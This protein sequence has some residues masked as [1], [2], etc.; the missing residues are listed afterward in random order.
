[1]LSHG[2]RVRLRMVQPR[3]GFAIRAFLADQGLGIDELEL[4]RLLRFDPRLRAVICASA[5]IDAREVIVAVGGID[6]DA[7]T[8]DTLVVDDDPE[9]TLRPLLVDALR[10][11]AHAHAA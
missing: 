1:M 3:D 4:D 5:L 10:G 9:R 11:R 2:Q 6:L 7:L 8:P